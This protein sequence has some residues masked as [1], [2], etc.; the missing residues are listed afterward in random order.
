MQLII[1]A[2]LWIVWCLL[3]SLLIDEGGVLRIKSVSG[4]FSRFYRI[5]YIIF[6]FVS[7]FP[8]L[9]YYHSLNPIVYYTFQGNMLFIPILLL[10]YGAVMMY[11]GC[12]AHDLSDF[13]GINRARYGERNIDEKDMQFCSSGILARVR[14]PWYGGGLA[15][16][17][18]VGQLSN[19]SLTVKII[20]SLY[21]IIGARLEEYRLLSKF[22]H[23]YAQ[24]CEGVP[25]FFPRLRS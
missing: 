1:L 14:H 19:V 3:H 9:Y 24:Y 7:L 10:S 6:S 15:L 13:L 8:P 12:R 21:L 11:L 17:W 4:L 5:F 16:I 25:R 20:L 22:G 2:L 18:A 23:K